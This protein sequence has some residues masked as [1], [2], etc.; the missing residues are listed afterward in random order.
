MGLSWPTEAHM[1]FVDST[2]RTLSEALSDKA[3]EKVLVIGSFGSVML[4]HTIASTYRY[5]T[6]TY[7]YINFSLYTKISIDCQSQHILIMCGMKMLRDLSIQSTFLRSLIFCQIKLKWII[8]T[9]TIITAALQPHRAPNPLT[10]L[11][12]RIAGF[13]VRLMY[14]NIRF[15]LVCSWTV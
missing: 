5:S 12:S 1:V 6:I 13:W 11:C 7:T 3:G 14:E 15:I 2:K 9:I 10:G 4:F 8:I